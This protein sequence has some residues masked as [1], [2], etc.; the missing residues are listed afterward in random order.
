MR[1][2]HPP[3][4]GNE[5]SLTSRGSATQRKVVCSGVGLRFCMPKSLATLASETPFTCPQM[6]IVDLLLKVLEDWGDVSAGKIL[7][8]KAGIKTSV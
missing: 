6:H 5:P 8:V 2:P 7:Y 4:L 3:E 1:L